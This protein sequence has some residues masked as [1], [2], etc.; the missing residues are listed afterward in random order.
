M[1]QLRALSICFEM[2]LI[3]E[4][5]LVGMRV[6]GGFKDILSNLP[7]FRFYVPPH[8]YASGTI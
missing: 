7:E 2:T 1:V 4:G 5:P 3:Q 6:I 8:F